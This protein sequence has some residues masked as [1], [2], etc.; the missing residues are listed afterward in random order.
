MSTLTTEEQAAHGGAGTPHAPIRVLP[1]D[2]ST[3]GVVGRWW[4]GVVAAFSGIGLVLSDARLML[5]SLI[6]MLI[7]VVLFSALLTLGITYA[8]DPVVGWLGPSDAATSGFLAEAGHAVWALA[9]KILVWALVI[10]LSLIAAL[11]SGSVICD[12]FY[13]ALSER[14][15][16]LY[17]GHP[18][19]EGFSVALVVAGIAR[20]LT[21][22]ILR[23]T[24]YMAV[25]IPLWLLSLTPAAVVATPLGLVWTWLFFAYE[26]L[27]RPMVR[28]APAGSTRLSA[29]F[30]HKALFIGFGMV[31]W[32]LSF[33][34]LTAPL[35][36]VSATRLYL[37]LAADAAAPTTMPASD[38]EHLQ[39]RGTPA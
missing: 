37:T 3:G 1:A 15:E 29:L 18:V 28:H 13:D 27:A 34:P 20:E 32:A 38:R 26:F 8:V 36:V 25:A 35:L 9:V 19:G 17:V 10:G 33:I 11:V 21:A 16:E 7:H 6:P 5:L 22:T 12:P 23:L 2:P 14:V 24:V 30:G 39:R 31:A 4:R